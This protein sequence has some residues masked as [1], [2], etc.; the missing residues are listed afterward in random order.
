V[1]TRPAA[2]GGGG[3]GGGHKNIFLN[4]DT[5]ENVVGLIS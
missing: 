5:R 2:A 1:V 4:K 3:G